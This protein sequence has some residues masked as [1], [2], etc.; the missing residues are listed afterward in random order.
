MKK[1]IA[2][3]LL[4]AAW[5]TGY[6]QNAD[7]NQWYFGVN[8]GFRSNFMRFSDIDKELYPSH[9]NLNSGVFSVFVQYE[10]GRG[11]HFALRPQFSFLPRGGKLTNIGK[12]LY[13][14]EETDNVFYNLKSRYWDIRI[15]IMYNFCSANSPIRPYL[16]VAPVV[17][18]STR[19]NIDLREEYTDGSYAGYLLDLSD[20]N[21]AKAYFALM[22]GV[23]FK[24]QFH[25]DRHKLFWGLEV[26]YEQGLT[27][28][29]GAKEK[30]GKAFDLLTSTTRKASGTRKFSGVEVTATLGIPFSIF[31]KQKPAPAVYVAP[32]PKPEPEPEP[33][34][35][36]EKPC[37][38]LEEIIDLMIKGEPIEGKTICAVDDVIN[39]DFGKSTI[40]EE[41][42]QYLD[43]LALVL[44]RLNTRIE[45]KGH[46][47]N[48]GSE[49][50][51]MELSKERAR[52]VTEYLVSKGVN[53]NKLSYSYYGMTKP[54]T[55]NDT[56]KGRALNRR[57]EFE[58]LNNR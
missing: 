19:G 47:D 7:N 26:S 49:E 44:I 32:T 6:A 15:P 48:V 2:L 11:N 54:L 18:F 34:V 39:F 21:M 35:E 41:S 16:Y 30:D 42:Y 4:C 5:Q 1:F 46:T 24:H 43:R 52:A 58:I 53:R 22:F 8:G 14:Y 23:G 17:G 56:E 45:V 36:K 13:G 31:K 40:K 50:F 25:I 33:V 37:Y 55:S 27:D 51:N 29:Y 28:T 12:D 20:A 10:F 9:E 3:F 57:V 38:T